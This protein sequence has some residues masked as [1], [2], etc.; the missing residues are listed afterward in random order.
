MGVAT[1]PLP[2]GSGVV[3]AV[4]AFCRK[5][6]TRRTTLIAVAILAASFYPVRHAAEVKPYAT[7]LLVSLVL[8]ID[9]M[10][11]SI[12]GWTPSRDGWR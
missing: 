6:T 3:A 11:A 5:A 4:L 12:A 7:D 10:D 1:D 9:G 2:G 8:T